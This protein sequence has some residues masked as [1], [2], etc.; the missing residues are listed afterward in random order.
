MTK[1]LTLAIATAALSLSASAATVSGNCLPFPIQFANGAGNGTVSCQ[2]FDGTTGTVTGVTLNLYADYTFGGS[3]SNDVQLVFTMNT[4]LGVTWTVGSQAIDVTG[5]GVSAN[6]AT[7]PGVPFADSATGG[8]TN[9]NFAS[10]FNVAVASHIVGGSVGTSSGGVQI[11]YTYAPTVV[12][13]AT[14]E[15]GSISL[16]GAGLIGLGFAGRKRFATK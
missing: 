6:K 9:A 1:F 2:G 8:I 10:A 4:P 11:T 16:L 14:P 15:P 5:T 12:T 13:G 7:N 3:G